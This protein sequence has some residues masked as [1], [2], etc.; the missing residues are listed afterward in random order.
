LV[1]DNG[2]ATPPVPRS[3]RG[4]SPITRTIISLSTIP[5]RFYLV[6]KAL[7]RLLDQSVAPDR[8]EL[9][10]PRF[11]RRFPDVAFCL[12]PV[13]DG[14]TIEVTDND[15]GPATKVLPCARK[16]RGTDARIVYCDDDRHYGRDWLK[17]LLAAAAEHP[18]AAI[19]AWGMDLPGPTKRQWIRRDIGPDAPRPRVK[20]DPKLRRGGLQNLHRNLPY[21]VWREGV[22]A[23]LKLKIWD[24]PPRKKLVAGGYAD[25]AEGFSGVLVKPEMFD[26][27]AFAIP[28]VLWAVDDIWLSGCLA[29]KGI[30]I[31]IEKVVVKGGQEKNATGSGGIA[32]LTHATI[33]GHSRAEA[34]R[35]AIQHFRDTHGIWQ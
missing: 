23:L 18:K 13:P 24:E 35:A 20:R 28:P 7:Q 30:P 4:G 34:N 3:N 25:I 32:T 5:P 29:V 26:D 8:I 33:D 1:C 15:L 22:R 27:A 17:T 6:G 12:P 10:I 16:H 9:W 11:Y 21:W 2:P 19:A 31:W 14:V